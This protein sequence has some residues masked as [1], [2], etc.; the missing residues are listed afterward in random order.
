M[1]GG[2]WVHALPIWTSKIAR[3]IRYTL[4]VNGASRPPVMLNMKPAK[5]TLRLPYF[6][7]SCPE[8]KLEIRLNGYPQKIKNAED[9]RAMAGSM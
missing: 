5:I 1:R 3:Y 6:T 8:S 9:R 7:K 4:G 2:F